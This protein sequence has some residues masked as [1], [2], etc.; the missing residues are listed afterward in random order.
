MREY[1]ADNGHL[2]NRILK[3]T[4]QHIHRPNIL[5]LSFRVPFQ[6]NSPLFGE[7]SKILL[8]ALTTLNAPYIAPHLW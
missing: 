2:G 8:Y 7:N 1:I 4:Q 5:Q 3:A 6:I